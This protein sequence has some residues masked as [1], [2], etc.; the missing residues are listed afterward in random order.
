M[1][2]RQISGRTCPFSNF[3]ETYAF[4]HKYQGMLE[5]IASDFARLES[6]TEMAEEK[7]ADEFTNSIH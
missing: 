5:V 3:Q 7:A 2:K 6:E 1:N 4:D